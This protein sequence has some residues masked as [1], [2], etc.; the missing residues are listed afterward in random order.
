MDRRR[1]PTSGSARDWALLVA[2][3]GR[4]CARVPWSVLIKSTKVL[5]EEKTVS[6]YGPNHH[7][8]PFSDPHA[9][10]RISSV[11]LSLVGNDD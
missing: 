5:Y 8:Q 6:A 9:L 1:S 4:M 11:E 3:V 7:I 2:C 10:G